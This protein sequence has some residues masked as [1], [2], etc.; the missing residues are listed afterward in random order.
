MGM[1][2]RDT[3]QR[4]TRHRDRGDARPGHTPAGASRRV[5]PGQ[6]N[7]VDRPRRERL[8]QR[9]RSDRGRPEL[10]ARRRAPSRPAAPA[11][12]R[13]RVAIDQAGRPHPEARRLPPR[14]RRGLRARRPPGRW[15]ARRSWPTTSPPARS[16]T[17]IGAIDLVVAGRPLRF[18]LDLG[19]SP[20]ARFVRSY[21][22]ARKRRTR[23]RGAAPTVADGRHAAQPV[24]TTRTP[25]TGHGSARR[26]RRAAFWP[27]NP[28]A[29]TSTDR[30][31]PGRG[32]PSR[33]RGRSRG[34]RGR[35]RGRGWRA[36]RRWWRARAATSTPNAPAAPSP[37]PSADLGAV[38]ASPG[39]RAEHRPQ[40]PGLG[41]VALGGGRGVGDQGVDLARRH[42]RVGQRPA[43]GRRRPPSLGMGRGHVVG[44]ARAPARRRPRPAPAPPG[45][46]PGRA[47]P[48]RRRPPPPTPPS[49]SGARRRGGRPTTGRRPPAPAPP[50]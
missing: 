42:P 50:R 43:H 46:P 7:G 26:R 13:G 35:R 22:A 9:A 41:H 37:W 17:P 10:G 2:D 44:V 6:W 25:F 31:G 12:R 20:P 29:L 27:P 15:A 8:P 4:R 32:S 45:P 23:R 34:R 38:T 18:D 33:G 39:C 47:A 40:G 16:R 5:C 21:L 30:Q 14:R 11:R 36:A 49:R 19:G 28:D 1:P 48:A 3:G 24:T